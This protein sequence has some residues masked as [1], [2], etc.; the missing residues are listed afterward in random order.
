[1]TAER[2][3]EIKGSKDKDDNNSVFNSFLADYSV[4]SAGL[5]AK[6]SHK[7]KP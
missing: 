4:N 6:K 5:K 2:M 7:K 3:G 1:M